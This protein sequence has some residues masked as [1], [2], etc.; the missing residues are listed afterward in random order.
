MEANKGFEK[1]WTYDIL[2][3]YHVKFCGTIANYFNS[4]N[5]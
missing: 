5:Y 4:L 2:L 1:I 3:L